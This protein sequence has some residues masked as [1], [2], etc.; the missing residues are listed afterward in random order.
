MFQSK[1]IYSLSIYNR[2]SL[3]LRTNN[4]YTVLWYFK[5]KYYL[6]I[7]LHLF[8][9]PLTW[10]SKQHENMLSMIAVPNALC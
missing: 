9:T 7:A 1:T 8:I 4:H 5:H 3:I 10:L 6:V 2:N